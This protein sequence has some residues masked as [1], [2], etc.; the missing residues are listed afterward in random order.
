[1]NEKILGD[2]KRRKYNPDLANKINEAFEKEKSQRD[3][4]KKIRE[5]KDVLVK[6]IYSA[7]QEYMTGE[8]SPDASKIPLELVS[9]IKATKEAIKEFT[10]DMVNYDF[11]YNSDNPYYKERVSKYLKNKNKN[12]IDDAAIEKFQLSVKA[13]KACKGK[14]NYYQCKKKY[15]NENELK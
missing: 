1:M 6:K 3:L 15:M 13:E 7:F 11:L 9:H 10:L 14:K 4:M 12:K 5:P 2:G 8:T